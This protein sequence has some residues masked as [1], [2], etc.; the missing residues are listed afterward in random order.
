MQG[1]DLYLLPG[2]FLAHC[3]RFPLLFYKLL[4]CISRG[5]TPK[6]KLVISVQL[7]ANRYGYLTAISPLIHSSLSGP[8]WKKTTH[9][10]LVSKTAVY[11]YFHVD[12]FKLSVSQP[13]CHK[14][15]PHSVVLAGRTTHEQLIAKLLSILIFTHIFD[16]F[17]RQD[18]HTSRL[19]SKVWEIL[20]SLCSS[21]TLDLNIG[22]TVSTLLE[23]VCY[24]IGTASG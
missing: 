17:H 2:R 3:A 15:I 21:N 22:T 13:K 23:T 24:R 20:G 1:R 9:R 18:G 7:P 5:L 11:I 14:Y 12:F 19:S 4:I 6:C 10:Q 8:R 16:L